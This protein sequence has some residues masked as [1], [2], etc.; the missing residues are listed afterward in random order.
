MSPVPLVT[1]KLVKPTSEPAKPVQREHLYDVPNYYR[2]KRSLA[3]GA[4][5]NVGKETAADLLSSNS[6]EHNKPAKL[7]SK[8]GRKG[9]AAQEGH[10]P[11]VIAEDGGRGSVSV[12]GGK[13]DR[14]NVLTRLIGR[15]SRSGS[16]TAEEKAEHP[17]SKSKKKK[18]ERKKNR[19]ASA[20]EPE[21]AH[22][23]DETDEFV[24]NSMYENLKEAKLKKTAYSVSCD[25]ILESC[26]MAD[27]HSALSSGPSSVP[28][29]LLRPG[30][31]S[32]PV[33]SSSSVPQP[34]LRS[35][36][37]T[38]LSEDMPFCATP[39]ITYQNLQEVAS[40]NKEAQAPP[41]APLTDTPSPL[42]SNVKLSSMPEKES[43]IAPPTDN[44]CYSNIALSSVP[45]KDLAP[46]TKQ[47][48]YAEV[49]ILTNE[50]PR[51]KFRIQKQSSLASIMVE[52]KIA[53]G[54]NRQRSQS[55][56]DS[57]DSNS[58]TIGSG[59]DEGV[60]YAPLDF[61]AM[62]AVAQ[63]REEHR[64]IRNFEGLLERHNV[65]EME[66]DVQRRRKLNIT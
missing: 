31:D 13:K 61:M 14:Q 21:Q 59:G 50:P 24:H 26:S 23:S 6:D 57:S 1:H 16:T 18:K 40:D 29:P 10:T 3:T 22:L 55:T 62:S 58:A 43:P 41:H 33:S 19:R 11:L 52:Q 38:S 51:T 64:D 36:S 8:F 5:A 32:Y 48:S 30:G 15:K 49:E 37:P 2:E 42:Y 54:F 9:S 4:S 46:L 20:M 35:L 60:V 47:T 7:S 39:T 56:H 12:K 17:R 28:H 66:M 27:S 65:R 53:P 44:P 45:E 25:N 34:R 63:I